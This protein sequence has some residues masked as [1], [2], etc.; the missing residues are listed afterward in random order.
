MFSPW[1]LLTLEAP[2]HNTWS[3]SPKSA[4]ENGVN[5]KLFQ[6]V[7]N[8]VINALST[9]DVFHQ[10][11]TV[12]ARVIYRMKSKFRNDK[13]LKKMV[14]LNQALLNYY[15]MDLLKEYNILKSII[16]IE[17]GKYILPSKQMIEYVLV[18]TQGY[19]Q[20]MARIEE[21]ARCAGHYLKERIKLGHAWS[22]SLFAFAVVS[23]L[24]IFSRFMIVECCEW[25]TKL[26]QCSQNLKY[27]GMN[28][29]PQNQKL[30]HNLTSW[31]NLDNTICFSHDLISAVKIMKPIRTEMFYNTNELD[32][33]HFTKKGT[34]ETVWK[35]N[36]SKLLE[37]NDLEN[38]KKRSVLT[39]KI[40]DDINDIGEVIDRNTLEESFPS[41]SSH[42]ETS[43]K[44]KRK[45]AHNC[46]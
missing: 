31:L 32:D 25:Y 11:A 13:G 30:L 16:R 17:D 43:L 28:W 38:C 7:V 3:I 27:I 15:N 40:Y 20:L 26:Y 42:I 8:R 35:T 2:P 22:I 34:L 12:L 6:S 4:K 14:Q 41:M 1:S 10:E 46:T 24:W 29:L 36:I 37:E 18:R 9:M 39:T 44:K 23:R 5:I 21:V 33:K 19:V 45:R